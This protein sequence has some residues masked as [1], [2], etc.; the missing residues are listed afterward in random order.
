MQSIA[1]PPLPPTHTHQTLRLPPSAATVSHYRVWMAQLQ[2]RYQMYNPDLMR[3]AKRVYVGNLPPNIGEAELRGLLNEMMVNSNGCAQPGF[4]ITSCKLYP[5]R[6]PRAF[7]LGGARHAGLSIL[8]A[9]LALA[10][11]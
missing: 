7:F 9:G 5:V 10:K 8:D 6:R 2:S 11:P 4:P 1:P 3:P